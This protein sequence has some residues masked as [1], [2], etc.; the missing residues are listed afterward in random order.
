MQTLAADMPL[1]TTANSLALAQR[2]A[3]IALDNKAQDVVL[4]DLRGVTDMT[5]FFLI[6]SGTSDTHA[7][8]VGEH[9]IE[10]MKKEGSPAHHVEGL[11]KGRWVLLDFVDFVVHVFHPTLRNFYQLE[12]LWSDAEQVPLESGQGV[13]CVTAAGRGR[14]RWLLRL[15]LLAACGLVA[16]GAPGA[17]QNYFGQ[18]QVQYDTFHWQMLET[19]H[20][21]I[22]F[23]PQ[24][25]AATTMAARMAE[26]S[27]ARLS[28]ML[29]HQFR[30]KKPIML[31]SSRTDFGQNNVTGD[32]GEGTGGVT[33]AERHRMLLNFTGD[34]RSFEHVLTHE[35]VHAFQYDIFA[36]GKAG[37]GLRALVAVSSAAVVR[38]RHGG[39][40]VA[41]A[42]PDRPPRRGCATRR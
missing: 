23:Y 39:V 36:R 5:D 26:R 8:A 2:A 33:E 19:E 41:R 22:Y 10:E 29:D 6:A 27:Y 28:R 35:M 24:E 34:Y 4:L 42:E 13:E 15:A 9:L 40:S 37:N 16:L 31:F 17:A 11:E 12:R 7:R 18:N 21:I 14:V 32:L 30:E 1:T 25:R 3:Q 38:R 20:F